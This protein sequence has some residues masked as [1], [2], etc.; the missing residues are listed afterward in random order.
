MS[1]I[2]TSLLLCFAAAVCHPFKLRRSNKEAPLLPRVLSLTSSRAA[3]TVY[4]ELIKL[5]ARHL[6][7]EYQYVELLD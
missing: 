4:V 2:S 5:F 6:G 7:V 1:G 3:E